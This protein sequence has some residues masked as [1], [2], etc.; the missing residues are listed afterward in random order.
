MFDP[1][2]HTSYLQ[3]SKILKIEIQK[4][5]RARRGIRHVCKIIFLTMSF[6][7]YISIPVFKL[8]SARA[9]YKN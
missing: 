4:Q 9:V 1:C 3:R 5:Y 7:K 6:V 2:K 8:Q